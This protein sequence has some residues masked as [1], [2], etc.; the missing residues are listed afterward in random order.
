[1]ITNENML[2]MLKEL[3]REFPDVFGLREG[4]RIDAIDLKGNYDD[5]IDFDEELLDEVRIYYKSKTILI[6]RYDRDNWEI[7]DEDYIK[8]EDFREVGKI[9]SIVMKH[10]SRIELDWFATILGIESKG[11]KGNERKF[12]EHVGRI[13]TWVSR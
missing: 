4:L 9:L 11:G 1:M 12:R 8:F 5:D 3:N 2:N 10:I 6:K 13:R 7:E